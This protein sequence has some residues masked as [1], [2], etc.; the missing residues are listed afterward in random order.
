MY[1]PVNGGEQEIRTRAVYNMA[2]ILKGS[3]VNPGAII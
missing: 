1:K 3:G 2:M